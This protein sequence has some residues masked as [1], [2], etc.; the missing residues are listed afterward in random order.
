MGGGV[1][2]PT[3][4]LNALQVQIVNFEGA[5][6]KLTK[7]IQ[8]AVADPRLQRGY[9]QPR[10]C[11]NKFK[12]SINFI[13]LGSPRLTSQ[14]FLVSLFHRKYNDIETFQMTKLLSNDIKVTIVVDS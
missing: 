7:L 3:E 14:M 11:I 12:K 9:G 13:F 1:N 4:N 6:S 2:R 10:P 8:G 5:T